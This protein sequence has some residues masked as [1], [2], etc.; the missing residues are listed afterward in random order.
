VPH[1]VTHRGNDRQLVFLTASD[2]WAYLDLLAKESAAHG[3]AF[4]GFSLM[5]NHV[6]LVARPAKEDSLAKALGKAHRRYAR[7]FNLL[8]GRSGH[9]WEFRYFS[10]PMDDE[11]TVRALRYVERNPVRAGMVQRAWDYQWSS[12]PCH[13]G[14][15]ARSLLPLE[16]LPGFE[17]DEWRR[18]LMPDE[19]EEELDRIRARTRT[20]RPFAGGAFV[21]TLEKELGR[22]LRP[23]R[24]G[25]P[26]ASRTA[27]AQNDPGL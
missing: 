6:H 19:L 9:V 20:G 4:L 23:R 7:R 12:A 15:T 13:C 27:V 1:H 8:R 2:R 14:M 11:H 22:P 18:V 10:C 3:V 21:H 17:P 24:R 5:T 26:E 25:R 16:P